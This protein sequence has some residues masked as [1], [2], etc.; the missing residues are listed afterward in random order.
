MRTGSRAAVRH[1]A[2]TPFSVMKP[3]IPMKTKTISDFRLPPPMRISVL[4]PQPE[5]S[6][7][8]NPNRNPPTTSESAAI[9]VPV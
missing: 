1:S 4:L 9:R 2:K 6:V 5:P 3:E 8:P 7:M